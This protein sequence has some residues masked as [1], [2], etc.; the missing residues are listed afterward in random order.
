MHPR[1]QRP[2]QNDVLAKARAG[3]IAQLDEQVAD[4]RDL[5]LQAKRA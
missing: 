5:E 1:T 3:A 4:A 2:T